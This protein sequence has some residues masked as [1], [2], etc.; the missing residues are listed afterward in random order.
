MLGQRV[1]LWKPE[2]WRKNPQQLTSWIIKNKW[3]E[4]STTRATTEV[5]EMAGKSATTHGSAETKNGG[6]IL[7]HVP[8]REENG[9]KIRNHL[10]QL[11]PKNDGKFYDTCVEGEKWRENPKPTASDCGNRGWL[12]MSCLNWPQVGQEVCRW[13]HWCR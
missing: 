1:L 9:G 12:A 6:K 2:K 10:D 5:K 4:N 7:Q 3:R 8:S 13:G 11:K